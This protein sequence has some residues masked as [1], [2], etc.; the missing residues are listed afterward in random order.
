VCRLCCAICPN[1]EKAD[2]CSVCDDAFGFASEIF[3]CVEL[4]CSVKTADSKD[5][6]VVYKE[7]FG[8]TYPTKKWYRV[9]ADGLVGT[10]EPTAA[11]KFCEEYDES[12]MASRDIMK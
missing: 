5:V 7:C 12:F 10:F 9:S 4:V 2:I 11:F 8:P 1:G 3:D 6:L